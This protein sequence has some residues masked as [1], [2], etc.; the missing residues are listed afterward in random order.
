MGSDAAG[1]TGERVMPK[2]TDDE[3]YLL[4]AIRSENNS[5]GGDFM[6][7]YIL[8]AVAFAGFA[9]YHENTLMM[10]C[11]FAV[12]CGFRIYEERYHAQWQSV[13]RSIIAKYDQAIAQASAT[14]FDPSENRVPN[15]DSN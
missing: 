12:V 9:A 15:Q 2:F 11:A 5:S 10:L 4:T 6:W 13:F 1:R 3:Q 14:N 8:G 7:G